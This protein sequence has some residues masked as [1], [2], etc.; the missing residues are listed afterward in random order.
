MEDG[1]DGR[2]KQGICRP[3]GKGME[4]ELGCEIL[5]VSEVTL[6]ES[7][8]TN[9]GRKRRSAGK[10]L[11]AEIFPLREDLVV[12]LESEREG[13]QSRG[14]KIMQTNFRQL[15]KTNV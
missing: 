13:Q 1:V 4:Y 5:V 12:K 7:K 9:K 11:Q 8:Y 14:K 2:E 6:E 15:P 10:K 3:V